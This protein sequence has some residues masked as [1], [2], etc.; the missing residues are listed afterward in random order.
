MTLELN[1]TSCPP[2]L[3]TEVSGIG[4]RISF[5][6]QTLFLSLLSIRSG[7]REEVEKSLFLLI[8]TS[9]AMAISFLICGFQENPQINLQDGLVVTY[10]LAMTWVFIIIS[11]A[12]YHRFD[13][14]GTTVQYLSFVHFCF[15]L[16]SVLVFLV[17][18]E[19]FGS[20]RNCNPDAVVV[21]FRPFKA[22]NAGRIVGFVGIGLILIIYTVLTVKGIR[23]RR[24]QRE[25]ERHEE[26]GPSEAKPHSPDGRKVL[27]LDAGHSPNSK[28]MKIRRLPDFSGTVLLEILV[29]LF[30]WALGVMNTELLIQWNSF[31]DVDNGAQWQFGQVMSMLLVVPSF[32]DVFN[33]FKEEGLR[34]WRLVQSTVKSPDNQSGAASTN[35]SEFSFHHTDM[36]T[37]IG[38]DEDT[39]ERVMSDH[40]YRGH[41]SPSVDSSLVA[42]ST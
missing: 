29:V 37:P 41:E 32:M 9:I 5:Y 21:V 16:A 28:K 15:T 40:A 3:N 11:L 42:S 23:E 17:E 18:M 31:R 33:C 13:V 2:A 24:L 19:S 20:S 25:K 35:M 22:L 6:L 26:A 30:V 38:I 12:S 8:T 4:I 39:A 1:L 10:L 7:S 34:H 27:N 14:D 36:H